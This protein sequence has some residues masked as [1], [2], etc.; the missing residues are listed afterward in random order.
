[1]LLRRSSLRMSS[2]VADQT[3]S[4][5]IELDFSSL[6]PAMQ[7]VS[8]SERAIDAEQHGFPS[9]TNDVFRLRSAAS[10]ISG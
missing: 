6:L 7:A 1:M 3:V 4:K 5:R 8:K 9:I 2:P 10:V